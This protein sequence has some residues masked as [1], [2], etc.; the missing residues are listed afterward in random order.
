MGF[1]GGHANGPRFIQLYPDVNR[2]KRIGTAPGSRRRAFP[3][4]SYVHKALDMPGNLV[5]VNRCLTATR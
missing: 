3:T 2:A 5:H 4:V 1:R